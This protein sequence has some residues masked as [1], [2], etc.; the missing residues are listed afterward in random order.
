MPR[1]PQGF[2]SEKEREKYAGHLNQSAVV[3]GS[4]LIPAPPELL[5]FYWSFLFEPMLIG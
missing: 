3:V 1:F 4:N 2:L 5:R